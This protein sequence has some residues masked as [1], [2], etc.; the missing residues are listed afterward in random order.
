MNLRTVLSLRNEQLLATMNELE[1]R[2]QMM[3]IMKEEITEGRKIIEDLTRQL[4]EGQLTMKPFYCSMQ[5]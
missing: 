5:L 4:V 1:K 2:D 3:T